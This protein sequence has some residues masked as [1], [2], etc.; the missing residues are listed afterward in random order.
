MQTLTDTED[1]QMSPRF[2]GAYKRCPFCAEKIQAQAIKCRYCN[3]FL[4][5]SPPALKSGGKWY[6]STA[7]MA[8]ALLTLG[9]L[10]LPVVWMHPKLKVWVKAAVSVAVIGLTLFLCWATVKMYA[11]L[12]SQ[13]RSLGM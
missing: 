5:S 2:E 11:N 12:I 10:A 9:P 1:L 13:F 8:A 6:H 4:V 3:E 7:A